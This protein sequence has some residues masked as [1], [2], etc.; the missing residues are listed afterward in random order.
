MQIP[1]G[2]WWATFLAIRPYENDMFNIGRETFLLPVRWE[3]DW[4][5]ILPRGER[6]PFAME[7][8][9]LPEQPEPTPPTSGNFGYTDTFDGDDLALSWMGIRDPDQPFYQ[10]KDGALHLTCRGGLGDLNAV[11]SF[12]GRR[13]QH[14]IATVSTTVSFDPSSEGEMAGIAAVQND[15]HLMF[16]GITQTDGENRVALYR[17]AGS[18]EGELVNSAAIPG[19][20]DVTLS[21]AFNAGKMEAR[22]QVNGEQHTLAENV[23]ATNLSTNVAGGFVGTLIGPYCTAP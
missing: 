8:P 10:I 22:Y 1:N 12:L 4:P 21:L 5:Y 16:L 6:I 7:K 14:H 17:H 13:Q 11:P 20:R 2:D 9:E 3:N 23:D 19:T 15:Q 18:P